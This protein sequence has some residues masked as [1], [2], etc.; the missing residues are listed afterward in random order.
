MRRRPLGDFA[1]P[2]WVETFKS[3]FCAIL[4]VFYAAL[5]AILAASLVFIYSAAKA[6]GG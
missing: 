2:D 3:W 1:R 5:L 4:A 6:A